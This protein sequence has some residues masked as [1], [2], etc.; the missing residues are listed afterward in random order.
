[1]F[2]ERRESRCESETSL[3]G[4][5]FQSSCEPANREMFSILR[6]PMSVAQPVAISWERGMSPA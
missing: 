6:V 3:T 2:T 5:D 4:I 1:M